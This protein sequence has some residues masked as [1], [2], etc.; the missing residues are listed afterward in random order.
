MLSDFS[1]LKDTERHDDEG[2]VDDDDDM[3]V[4]ARRLMMRFGWWL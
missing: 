1:G 4:T 2:R 3:T